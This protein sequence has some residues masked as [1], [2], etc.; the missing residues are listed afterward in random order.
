MSD[1][2]VLIKDGSDTITLIK[3]DGGDTWRVVD[4]TLNVHDSQGKLL[5]SF[6]EW[7]GITYTDVAAQAVG[8]DE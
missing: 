8:G 4:H 7:A 3:I 2:T 5:A 6:Y 1:V